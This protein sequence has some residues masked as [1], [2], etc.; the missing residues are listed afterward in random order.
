[1][2]Q[3]YLSID[4]DSVM[5]ILES[6]DGK[7]LVLDEHRPDTID[8]KDDVMWF[9]CGAMELEEDTPEKAAARVI[10]A[11]TGINLP[12]CV[13]NRI[14]K[15]VNPRASSKQIHYL[16]ALIDTSK[17]RLTPEVVFSRRI[18][19]NWKSSL[20]LFLDTRLSDDKG[21]ERRSNIDCVSLAC[22]LLFTWS[23]HEL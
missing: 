15:T 16:H 7:F 14:G 3:E 13:F 10:F 23:I 5:V 21:D 9:P 2:E 22:L 12:A 8:G 20:K 1:M 17:Y 4:K 18:K 19:P 6:V 11:H